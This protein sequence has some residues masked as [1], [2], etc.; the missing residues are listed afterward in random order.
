MELTKELLSAC[1]YCAVL[2]SE[3]PTPFVSGG[4]D[5]GTD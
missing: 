5:R 4:D 3:P 2:W 1:R